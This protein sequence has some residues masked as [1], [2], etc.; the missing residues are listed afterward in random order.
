M[1]EQT[2]STHRITRLSH[3]PAVVKLRETWGSEGLQSYCYLSSSR[4]RRL[5]AAAHVN[6]QSYSRAV[7]GSTTLVRLLAVS[8]P[9][10][11]FIY[12]GNH[13]TTHVTYPK[14]ARG[15]E[16]ISQWMIFTAGPLKHAL[17]SKEWHPSSLPQGCMLPPTG[18]HHH[19][20]V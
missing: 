19:M 3:C 9:G 18:L 20:G 11:G 7:T 10:F 14:L 17:N 13:R 4:M 12:L 16:E 1:S 5:L 6:E 8:A 2:A 15:E